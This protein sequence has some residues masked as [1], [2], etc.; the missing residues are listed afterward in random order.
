[1]W[2]GEDDGDVRENGGGDDDRSKK[3]R[4]KTSKKMINFMKGLTKLMEQM[5]DL[6][7]R[8]ES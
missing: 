1:M 7:V 3:T 4:K 6:Q 5:E 2:G 8:R